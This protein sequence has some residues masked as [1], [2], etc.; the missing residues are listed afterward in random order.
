MKEQSDGEELG[1][2]RHVY[3]YKNSIKRWVKLH[4]QMSMIIVAISINFPL[5]QNSSQARNLRH[6]ISIL[7]SV[8]TFIHVPDKFAKDL[9]LFLIY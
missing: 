1:M 3:G 5:V 7:Y 6:G 8:Q 2:R 9:N 4:E